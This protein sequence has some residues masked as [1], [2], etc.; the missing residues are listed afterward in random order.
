[1]STEA[2]KELVARAEA[3]RTVRGLVLS[4]SQARGM[5]TVHSDFDVY[6]VVDRRGGQWTSTRRTPA[7]DEIVYT[8][9]EL[10]DTSV[11]WQRYSFRGAAV[12]LDRL[13][14]RVAR[15]GYRLLREDDL[16]LLGGP[17]W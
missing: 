15:N 11:T 10:A 6:V 2:F 7:L 16:H 8:V 12:L 9:E 5:A 3:D 1:M 14:G 13:G 17:D 4:G